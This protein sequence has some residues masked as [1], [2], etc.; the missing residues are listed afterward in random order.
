MKKIFKLFAVFFCLTGLFMACQDDDRLDGNNNNGNE[1]KRE[2]GVYAIINNPI[3]SNFSTRGGMTGTDAE[4]DHIVDS[5]YA[6]YFQRTGGVTTAT[7]DA[8]Y[9]Y[10]GKEKLQVTF[11]SLKDSVDCRLTVAPLSADIDVKDVKVVFI[12]NVAGTGLFKGLSGNTAKTTTT[13]K[14][15]RDS[16]IIAN[17]DYVA[18]WDSVKGGSE[19]DYKINAIPMYACSDSVYIPKPEDYTGIHYINTG[20]STADNYYNLV[21]MMAKFTLLNKRQTKAQLKLSNPEARNFWIDSVCIV[22]GYSAGNVC[23]H[24][25]RWDST[26]NRVDTISI[27]RV[28]NTTYNDKRSKDSTATVMGKNCKPNW[29]AVPYNGT[30][31][32]RPEHGSSDHYSYPSDFGSIQTVDWNKDTKDK[33]KGTQKIVFY[34]FEADT[35]STGN[36]L[37]NKGN[38]YIKLV[39]SKMAIDKDGKDSLIENH[40][41]SYMLPVLALKT[42]NDGNAGKDSGKLVT[43]GTDKKNIAGPVLRN[44]HYYYTITG[45][46]KSTI[47]AVM[48]VVPWT[49]IDIE[50]DP[51]PLR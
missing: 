12:A 48:K 38:F 35:V 9:K 40:R 11:N 45:V 22:N 4:G 25:N 20:N 8:D 44:H 17:L 10:K 39:G 34:A 49:K 47:R 36:K 46:D 13:L 30:T 27:F 28:N 6:V 18:M 33:D 1:P 32:P 24:P 50:F 23:Y 37:G 42:R 2:P 15:Y 26:K 51:I 16:L 41:A 19:A 29:I 21:R 31:Y 5:L 43:V 3:R 7:T 14:G